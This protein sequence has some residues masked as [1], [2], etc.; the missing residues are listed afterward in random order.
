LNESEPNKIL[1][2]ILPDRQ[3]AGYRSKKEDDGRNLT[4]GH[5]EE[6]EDT[7]R[8]DNNMENLFV[9]LTRSLARSLRVLAVKSKEKREKRKKTP[10]LFP[11]LDAIVGPPLPPTPNSEK[12]VKSK[13]YVCMMKCAA[14]CCRYPA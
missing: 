12:R 7:E 10:S 4:G 2:A 9:Y 13:T 1:L 5:E 3:A 6:E 8:C 14:L 11:S